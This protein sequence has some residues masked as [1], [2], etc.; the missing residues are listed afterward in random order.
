MTATILD[1]ITRS[2]TFCKGKVSRADKLPFVALYQAVSRSETGK[3]SSASLA[4]EKCHWFYYPGTFQFYTTVPE[5][6]KFL[7]RAL[8]TGLTFFAPSFSTDRG[9]S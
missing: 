6:F 7:K 1:Y 8:L 2:W 5:H 4:N 3:N 9:D